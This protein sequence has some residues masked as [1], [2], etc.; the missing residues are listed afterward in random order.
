[1]IKKIVI[2]EVWV[3]PETQ[4]RFLY[5]NRF[6]HIERPDLYKTA[7]WIEGRTARVQVISDSRIDLPECRDLAVAYMTGRYSQWSFDL[8]EDEP[9]WTRTK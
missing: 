6:E 4:K 2:L 7:V 1:M 8:R 3:D 9:K 5:P